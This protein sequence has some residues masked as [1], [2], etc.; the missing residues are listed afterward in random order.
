MYSY[1]CQSPCTISTQIQASSNTLEGFLLPILTP[2]SSLMEK[3]PY[4]IGTWEE[5]NSHAAL[6]WPH[7][8][9]NISL[10]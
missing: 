5:G 7:R 3:A 1:L 9:V 6:T 8:L 2:G 10:G 4:T